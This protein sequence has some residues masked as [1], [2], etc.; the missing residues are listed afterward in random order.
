MTKTPDVF[1]F[2]FFIYFRQEIFGSSISIYLR[3]SSCWRSIIIYFFSLFFAQ[4][5]MKSFFSIPKIS[6]KARCNIRSMISFSDSFIYFDCDIFTIKRSYNQI[7]QH[8]FVYEFIKIH[9]QSCDIFEKIM[10]CLSGSDI[11]RY[12]YEIRK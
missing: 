4:Q 1:I 6:D 11:R 8:I 5:M 10:C 3:F 7:F 2:Y 9:I 12:I